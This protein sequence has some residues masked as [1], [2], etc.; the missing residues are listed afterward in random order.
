MIPLRGMR[1]FDPTRMIAACE[2]RGW[3]LYRLAQEANLAR[4]TVYNLAGG[5][6]RGVQ[7]PTLAA[8]AGALGCSVDDLFREPDGE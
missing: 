1:E 2:K 4:Q 3:T 8:L 6:S 5:S 7:A